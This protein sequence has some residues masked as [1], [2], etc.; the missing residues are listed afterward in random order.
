M[1]DDLSIVAPGSVTDFAKAI[2][3]TIRALGDVRK[4]VI[5]AADLY[6][7]RKARK[8]ASSLSKLAF[9]KAEMRGPLERIA[10][11]AGSPRDFRDI[12]AG[13]AATGDEVEGS[14]AFL[15][16]YKDRLRELHGFAA[17]MKLQEIIKSSVFW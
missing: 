6:D 17:A 16:K 11:G 4:I 7:H 3:E 13:L 12:A 10:V 8:A 9:S 1:N 2:R 15:G 14:I 5:G